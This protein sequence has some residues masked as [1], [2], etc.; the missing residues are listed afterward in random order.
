LSKR[1]QQ[2]LYNIPCQN[3]HERPFSRRRLHALVNGLLANAVKTTQ[4]TVGKNEP[5]FPENRPT[6]LLGV[7]IISSG[8]IF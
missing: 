2:A 7:A 1:Q 6:Q 4:L 3:H 5:R 8:F